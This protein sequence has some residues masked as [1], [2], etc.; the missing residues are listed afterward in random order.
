MWWSRRIRRGDRFEVLR[1][2]PV[3]GSIHWSAPLTSD[4]RCV[5][6]AGTV[7]VS[8]RDRGPGPF[9]LG[10]MCVPEDYAGFEE[11][12]V[13]EKDRLAPKYA[14]YSFIFSRWAI[15]TKLRRL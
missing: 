8:R 5:I 6:P 2:T 10:F 14:G 13:P 1:D 3:T 4:F 12:F 15:G 7:L 11:R 9:P